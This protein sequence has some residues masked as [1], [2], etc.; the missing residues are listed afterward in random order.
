MKSLF[1]LSQA[2]GHVGFWTSGVLR[3]RES[4]ILGEEQG[5]AGR[6]AAAILL[7]DLE[8]REPPSPNFSRCMVVLETNQK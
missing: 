4:R 6:D 1:L 3:N 2:L 8:F 7:A 5:D